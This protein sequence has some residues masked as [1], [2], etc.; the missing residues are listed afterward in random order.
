MR[1]KLL[2]FGIAKEIIGGSS[3][4]VTV[5]DNATI[6]QVK[7]H[8]SELYPDFNK[9]VKFNIAVNESY[10]EDMFVVSE[11]DELVILPPVSGG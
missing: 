1:I 5:P 10:E 3:Q 11:N 9:L 2:A 4:D 7:D 8:L 6:S